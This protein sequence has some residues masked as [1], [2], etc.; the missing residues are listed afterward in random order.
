[1]SLP[2][3][4]TSL[5]MRFEHAAFGGALG[6]FGPYVFILLA[7]WLATD[8]WRFLGVFSAY[9]LKEDSEIV[10][11][12]KCVATA[13]VAGVIGQLIMFPTGAL[14]TAPIW[15]RLVAIL[16]GALG[17]FVARQNVLVAIICAET[18]LIAG[19]WLFGG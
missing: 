18:C 11:W 14:A 7:G 6:D 5:T 19:W 12:I 1:M 13:L 10:R 4:Q 8:I 2:A 15:V 3:D 9:N 17:F 16:G